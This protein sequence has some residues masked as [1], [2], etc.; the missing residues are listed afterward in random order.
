MTFLINVTQLTLTLPSASADTVAGS[1]QPILHLCLKARM[2]QAQDELIR[3]NYSSRGGNVS[4]GTPVEQV[5]CVQFLCQRSDGRRNGR[6]DRPGDFMKIGFECDIFRFLN[7]CWPVD[8]VSKTSFH[9]LSYK[10]VPGLS[11]RT[12]AS[13]GRGICLA[14]SDQIFK[15]LSA[16]VVL[17]RFE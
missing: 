14:T 4:I 3:A 7:A 2:S 6:F 9:A 5:R 11:A 15:D 13:I 10:R 17:D 8:E 1:R 12:R 16:C